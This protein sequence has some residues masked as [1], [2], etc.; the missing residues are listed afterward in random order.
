MAQAGGENLC[1]DEIVPAIAVATRIHN[2][3][4]GTK[5]NTAYS[6]P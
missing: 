2:S 5:T 4:A 6:C 3:P 1:V